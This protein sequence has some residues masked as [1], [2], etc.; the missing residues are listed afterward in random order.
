MPNM[1]GIEFVQA[2]RKDADYRFTPILVLTSESQP[3]KKDEAR[4]S[5][6]TGWLVKPVSA[7]DLVKAIKQVPPGA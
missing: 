4:K 3:Q 1:G 5:G 7:Q 6:A 2:V